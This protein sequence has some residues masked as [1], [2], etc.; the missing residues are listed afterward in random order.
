MPNEHIRQ[1]SQSSVRD[2]WRWLHCPAT[3][4][5]SSK[6]SSPLALPRSSSKLQ[7]L[8]ARFLSFD[9]L[10]SRQ[11]TIDT[12]TIIPQTRTGTTMARDFGFLPI[13]KHL[14]WGDSREP[15]LSIPLNLLLAYTSGAST[16]DLVAG[17]VCR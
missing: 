8:R 9:K 5:S 11:L 17:S 1:Q 15:G 10:A 12:A 13:P 14:H 6:Q 4:C 2:S 16:S 7:G 3:A